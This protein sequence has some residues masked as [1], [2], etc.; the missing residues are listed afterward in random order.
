MEAGEKG[1][2]HRLWTRRGKRLQTKD[3]AAGASSA[4]KR[5]EDGRVRPSKCLDGRG[6]LTQSLCP[7]KTYF[8]TKRKIDFSK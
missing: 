3:M 8:K 6:L 7:V 1:S 5:P 2:P 4:R